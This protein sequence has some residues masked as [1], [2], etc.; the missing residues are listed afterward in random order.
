M[1]HF[2]KSFQ[3]FLVKVSEIFFRKVIIRIRI[4]YCVFCLV[5]C[6][7]QKHYLLLV[8]TW[9]LHNS[10]HERLTYFFENFV[11]RFLF[12]FCKIK[13]LGTKGTES[14]IAPPTFTYEL[15]MYPYLTALPAKII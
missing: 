14:A 7:R 11:L 4:L 5:L 8:S 6:S 9:L 10:F 12:Y 1:Q 15:K 2:Q 3:D 13:V